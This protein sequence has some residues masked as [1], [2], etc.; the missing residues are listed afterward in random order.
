LSA[1]PLHRGIVRR[2]RASVNPEHSAG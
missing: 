2:L 1:E